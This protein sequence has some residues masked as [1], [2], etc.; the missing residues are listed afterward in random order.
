[1]RK[2]GDSSHFP[3]RTLLAGRGG[4]GGFRLS[5][6]ILLMWGMDVI[7]K[8]LFTSFEALY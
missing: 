6:V 2:E 4:F 3:G 8:E 1:L 7:L 5:F